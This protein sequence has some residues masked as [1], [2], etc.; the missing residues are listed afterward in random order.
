MSTYHLDLV[1]GNDAN[2][3]A[4]WAN[5]WLTISTGAGA[6]DIAPTD[7]IKIAKTPDPVSIGTCQ[8]T[9][10]SKTVTRTGAAPAGS[11]TLLVNDC[12]SG[13]TAANSATVTHPTTDVKSGSARL[14][15][16]KATYATGT[17]YAYFA[18]AGVTDFSLFG[19]LSLWLRTDATIVDADRWTICLCSD[20]AGATPV[21]SFPVPAMS[22]S[23]W[24]PTRIAKS[25]GGAL[26][27]SIQSIA[28]YTGTSA[29]TGGQDLW[30][31]NINACNAFSLIS[32]LG[33]QSGVTTEGQ[34]AIQ[35]IN[36]TTL[37]LDADT[38]TL[39]S[40]GRGYAGTTAEVATYRRETVQIASSI[41]NDSGTDGAMITFS[42]G[43]NTSSG[44]QDGETW[45]DARGVLNTGL[46]LTAKSFVAVERMG[47]ARYNSG[48]SVSGSGC[49]F[50]GVHGT[51][52]ASTVFSGSSGLN[53]TYSNCTAV[54][55]AGGGFYVVL[56]RVSDCV[57]ACTAGDGFNAA[58]CTLTDCVARNNAT[59]G[60]TGT[61]VV[62][63]GLVAA[64][65]V[66]SSVGVAA[67]GTAV[68]R[69][70]TLG[71][72]VADVTAYNGR[73]ASQNHNA[74][75]YDSVYTDGGTIYQSA[76]DF[77][78][79]A[80]GK[81]W[82]L[83]TS[84]VTRTSSYPLKLRLPGVAVVAN[85]LVTISAR[86]RKAHATNVVGKLVM[87]GGQIAGVAADVVAT[88]ASATTEEELTITF[89]PTAAGV[90]VP[91]VW[92][93]YVAGHAAVCIDRLTSVTQAA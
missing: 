35:S 44:L 41:V 2:S 89:T 81:M 49:S 13:W 43:W 21:D 60:V 79:P 85:K 19:A 38:N 14:N 63:V 47:F 31:D 54:G 55:S 61:D 18:L 48:I 33:K 29:P 88:L 42:G 62:C 27:A 40:A 12:E 32:L 57:A 76:T 7:L 64:D 17:L 92:A 69:D 74:T 9:D 77:D 86:M 26:G 22:P 3:G 75:G 8:W 20:A 65:N 83:L 72:P 71:A 50:D 68:M 70:C 67:G 45:L 66:T 4:D 56:S 5:A 51:A 10:L 15:V 78:A 30:I 87:P 28:I 6:G 59:H 80:T 37:L 90:V 24:F 25:G 11:E 46:S 58:R 73:V 23:R 84:A 53:C 52:C 1:S 93:E 34:Y 39:S 16:T 91:E 36:G 82:T